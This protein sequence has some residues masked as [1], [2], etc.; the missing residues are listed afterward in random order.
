ML[1]DRLV[2]GLRDEKLQQSLL[3]RR[4]LML[5]LALDMAVFAETATKDAAEMVTP[6]GKL[7]KITARGSRSAQPRTP[8]T[9]QGNARKPCY[10]C[11]RTSHG[12]SDCGF[13]K[14]TCFHCGKV[15][16]VAQRCPSR[17]ITLDAEANVFFLGPTPMT[18]AYYCESLS[19]TML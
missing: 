10:R 2:C 11:G 13:R 4:D 1:R 3:A 19:T 12:D 17:K 14:K 9:K 18:T 5:D 16:H 6:E 15:E 7:L 8:N